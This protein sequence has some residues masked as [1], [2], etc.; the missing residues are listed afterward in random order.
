MTRIYTGMRC[1]AQDDAGTI[2]LAGPTLR[3]NTFGNTDGA[4]WRPRACSLLESYLF[5]GT[6][7]IPEHEPGK[8]C[9]ITDGDE[10]LDWEWQM[11][12]KAD[13]VAFWVPRNMR[14]L[15]GLTTN[16][17]FGMLL[18]SGKIVFGAPHDAEHVGYMRTACDRVGVPSA[19][20]L[21]A[22]MHLAVMHLQGGKDANAQTAEVA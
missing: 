1:D 5:R 2:F 3:A 7:I 21:E 19:Q 12:A 16:I 9:I 18:R 13:V 17:E 6:I 22:T 8:S 4:S 20:T 10:I 15:P 14:T 11:L